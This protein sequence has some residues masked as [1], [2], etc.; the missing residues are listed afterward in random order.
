M[1]FE[2]PEAARKKA[3]SRKAEWPLPRWLTAALISLCAL[4]LVSFT[5][6]LLMKGYLAKRKEEHIA[7]Q[8][9]IDS[10]Y[11]LMYNDIIVKYAE[12]NNLAPALV[13]AVIMNESSFRPDVKSGVG[14]TGLMQLMPDTAE[15]IAHKLRMDDVYSFNLMEDPDTNVRFGC[16]YLSYLSSLFNSNP[17]CVVCAY[18][19]GQGEIA[20]WLSN[21]LYSSDGTTLIYSNLPD[22]PTKTYA[23]R[24]TRDYG[25]Y[26][27]KYYQQ[28]NSAV[29][30]D[31]APVAR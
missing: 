29:S 30:G 6:Q 18:H 17:L 21:P 22:G 24:V 2:R 20:S 26:Q 8:K 19:A 3:S 28:D 1:S 11:P 31:S 16:W 14:A 5:A 23:G 4:L 7:E 25:I 12:E 13:A 27:K 10:N 9:A 15:W